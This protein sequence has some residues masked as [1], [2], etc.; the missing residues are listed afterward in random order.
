MY[1]HGV[2][3]KESAE[4]LIGGF[5][6]V[7]GTFHNQNALLHIPHTSLMAIKPMTFYELLLDRPVPPAAQGLP[8]SIK[9]IDNRTI[10]SNQY[11]GFGVTHFN[12]MGTE[13]I[14]PDR[15]DDADGHRENVEVI[16][17]RVDAE[18]FPCALFE[19]GDQAF[20]DNLMI[21]GTNELQPVVCL[22]M[23]NRRE[24]MILRCCE[25]KRRP[26]RLEIRETVV[27]R[28]PFRAE[29]VAITQSDRHF[30]PPFHNERTQ[31]WTEGAWVGGGH[32][33]R[34]GGIGNPQ[35]IR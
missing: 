33:W 25:P 11:T 3:R 12:G 9:V 1:R 22:Y 17:V 31:L 2:A 21:R 27:T 24:F 20:F 7:A 16:D 23:N 26:R 29:T 34:N 5:I 13:T 4:R 30:V 10:E 19:G 35:W 8:L 28:E 14:T 18:V 32:G 6:E 15:A